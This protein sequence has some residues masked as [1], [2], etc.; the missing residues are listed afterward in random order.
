[1]IPLLILNCLSAFFRSRYNLALEILALRQQL[2]VLKRK[3]PHPRLRIEDRIFWTLLR[4]LWPAWS[5]VLVIVKPETVV[6]WHRAG[7]RLFWRFRSRRIGRPKISQEIRE[8]IR[9]MKTDNP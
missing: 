1:M 2:G 6:T 3:Q 4:R 9:R 7:F 5:Q 8:L